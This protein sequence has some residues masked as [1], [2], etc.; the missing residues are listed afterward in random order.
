MLIKLK[1]GFYVNPKCI[2]S[3]E[4]THCIVVTLTDGYSMSFLPGYKETLPE[5]ETRIISLINQEE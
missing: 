1:P 3:I 5:C 4:V 2:R